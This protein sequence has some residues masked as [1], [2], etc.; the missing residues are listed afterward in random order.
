MLHYLVEQKVCITSDV[1]LF[2]LNCYRYDLML[3]VGTLLEGNQADDSQS[4]N[5]DQQC[6]ENQHGDENSTHEG[7]TCSYVLVSTRLY[8]LIL[9]IVLLCICV[10][11][12]AQNNQV[13]EEGDNAAGDNDLIMVGQILEQCQR[14]VEDINHRWIA[15]NANDSSRS[16]AA[17]TT[18]LRLAQLAVINAFDPRHPGFLSRLP[19]IANNFTRILGPLSRLNGMLCTRKT[20]Q[21]ED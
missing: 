7:G 12:D 17:E 20:I 19:I 9:I 13:E 16:I 1:C 4:E 8:C 21:A 6:S 2:V 15:L 10:V 11:D 18:L 3:F 5:N 14:E